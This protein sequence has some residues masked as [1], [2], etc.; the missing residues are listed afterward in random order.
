M[1]NKSAISQKV[2]ETLDSMRPYLNADG[3]DIELVDITDDFIVTVKLLGNCRTCSMS[4]MTMKAGI[5]EGIRRVFP[6]LKA[7]VAVEQT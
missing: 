7:V 4:N 3:G 6:D 5:E 1:F 2:K